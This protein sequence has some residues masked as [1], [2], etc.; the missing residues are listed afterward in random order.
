[1]SLDGLGEFLVA[2]LP[3]SDTASSTWRPPEILPE[4]PTFELWMEHVYS[5]DWFQGKN[6]GKSHI[7]LE[8]PWFPVDFPLNQPIDV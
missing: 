4:L 7:S 6:A 2:G 3:S 8:N 1:M 5:I